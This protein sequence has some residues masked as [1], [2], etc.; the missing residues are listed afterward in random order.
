MAFPFSSP[1]SLP[2]VNIE[3]H[4]SFDDEKSSDAL[5]LGS[6]HTNKPNELTTADI[7]AILSAHNGIRGKYGVGPL[8]WDNSLSDLAKQ[9]ADTCYWGHWSSNQT[10]QALGT[11]YFP[12]PRQMGENL[13]IWSDP[14]STSLAGQQGTQLWLNEEGEF[15]CNTGQCKPG[16]VCGHWTQ[17]LWK[18]TQ[19]VGCAL[20]TCPDGIHPKSWPSSVAGGKNLKYFVC[21][22]DPPGNFTGQRPFP[23]SGCAKPGSTQP[24]QPAIVSEDITVND[25]EH[26]IDPTPERTTR[27]QTTIDPT[28]FTPTG[29]PVYELGPETAITGGFQPIPTIGVGPSQVPTYDLGPNTEVNEPDLPFGELENGVVPSNTPPIITPADVPEGAFVPPGV[30]LITM[31]DAKIISTPTENNVKNENNVKYEN[32]NNKFI[33]E[34]LPPATDPTALMPWTDAGIG[35]TGR[36]EVF[37]KETVY[38]GLGAVVG[39]IVLGI[40]IGVLYYFSQMNSNR[41]QFSNNNTYA[42]ANNKYPF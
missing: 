24:T 38:G 21:E 25:S 37:V 41:K 17:M 30:T 2:L 20:R 5:A 33:Y 6:E 16:G 12:P 39:A 36:Q 3:Q 1:S 4:S 15:D 42:N 26:V 27:Y 34:P 7:Q 31:E 9:W 28:R 29:E 19:R 32:N 35:P 14:A 18:D 8:Q 23:S 10:K 11:E 13:S 40:I 22:Y